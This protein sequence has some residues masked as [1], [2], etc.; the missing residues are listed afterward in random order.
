MHMLCRLPSMPLKHGYQVEVTSTNLKKNQHHATKW[1]VNSNQSDWNRLMT[2]KLL[3]LSL[4]E[5]MHD[6]LLLLS[7]IRGDYDVVI[8]DIEEVV[9][10][11]R[12]TERGEYRTMKARI[13][14]TNDNFLEERNCSSTNFPELSMIMERP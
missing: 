1:I 9:E 13:N 5:E 10:T 4:H 6:L 2:L 8:S 11:T 3:P 12:Q 7:I 14:K